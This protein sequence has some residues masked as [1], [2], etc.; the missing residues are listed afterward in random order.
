MYIY[1]ILN[2]HTHINLPINCLSRSS[3]P[4]HDSL[5]NDNNIALG[6]DLAQ[7]LS[8]KLIDDVHYSETTNQ[9]IILPNHQ[10]ILELSTLAWQ[11]H[12]LVERSD[13]LW[14]SSSRY[15]IWYIEKTWK[16]QHIHCDKM[17]NTINHPHRMMNSPLIFSDASDQLRCPGLQSLH[18]LLTLL[19]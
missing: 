10:S 16:R 18:V 13:M 15:M 2:A 9:D 14:K 12:L 5:N 11:I 1:N 8:S 19:G 3:C 17:I 4:R 6:K 7:S